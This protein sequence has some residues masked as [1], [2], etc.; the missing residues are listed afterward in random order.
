M[1]AVIS[2]TSVLNYLGRLGQF[3]LLRLEFRQ[4][5]IPPAVN[6]ELRRRPDLPG[7]KCVQRAV[8]EGWLEV[9]SPQNRD[10]VR[11]LRIMLG[12]GEAEAIVLA[13]ELPSSLLLMDEAEGRIVA[14]QLKLDRIGTVGVL[15]RARKTGIIPQL[16]PLLDE[17][18]HQ[19]SFRLSRHV[20]NEALREVGESE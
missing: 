8:A 9:R 1:P 20:Y 7:A 5:L 10:A 11:S 3:E 19:H 17:L 13:Q 18:T 12:A 16:K 4:V 15:L 6:T 14:E 2:D